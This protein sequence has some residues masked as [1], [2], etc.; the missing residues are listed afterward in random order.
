[1][2]VLAAV[3]TVLAGLVGVVW[4]SRHYLIWCE[5]R[6]SDLLSPSS[7]GSPA[8]SPLI[9]VVVAARDEADNIET[10]VKSMLGQD[11]PNF[12]LIVCNDRSTDATASIVER[13][14][15]D[16]GRLRLINIEQLP[17]GWYGKSNAM[18]QGI[19][20]GRGEWICM[21]D[22]DCRQSSIRTLSVAMQYAH[23]T[24]ADLLS[25]LP[26]LEMRGFWENVVQP[27][28]GGVMMIWF[29]PDRVNDPAKP[30]AYANGAFILIKRSAY[31]AVGTHEAI[32]DCANED[33]HLAAR[34]K[35]A[36]LKLR[37]VRN[38]GLY[39][40]RMYTS[41]GEI[42]RGWGRI[43]YGT[44]GIFKRLSIS[45][46]VLLMMGLVPY[47]AGGLGLAMANAGVEPT[48]WWWACGLS[49]AAAVVLQLSV[50]YRYYKLIGARAA[51][52]WSYPLGCT[53]AAISLIISLTKL[54]RGA[55]LVW[56]K[57]SYST[58]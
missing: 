40:V 35:G 16:D 13:I 50:I 5:S 26:V 41:I 48:A 25:V 14:A 36:G 52:A 27:V 49:G 1:M 28:C 51:L 58:G 11:Y 20:S 45:L 12:E 22:A 34:V 37:V 31:E 39:L 19:A 56:K 24:G 2:S 54:R 17:A 53:M 33:M 47:A 44:F 23:E 4:T 18:Q 6:K 30:N 10:C 15:D 32:K 55:K 3:L 9:S 8:D 42:L 38:T 43:F 46:A 29:H 21:I 57:T 7:P